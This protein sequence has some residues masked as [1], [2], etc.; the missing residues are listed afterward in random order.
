MTDT[1][2]DFGKMFEESASRGAAQLRTGDKVSGTITL[3][4]KETVFVDLGQRSDGY[5]DIKDIL[6]AK[7]NLK[8]KEGDKVEAFCVGFTDEGIK[9]EMRISGDIFDSTIQDAFEAKIP[10]EGKVTGERKGGYTVQIATSEAF[11]P[12]SQIDARGV[13]KE[14]AEYIGQ[15]YSFVVTEYSEDGHNLVISRRRILEEEAQR[16]HDYLKDLLKV[17]EIREGT[18]IKV[19]PFGAFVD[20]GGIEGLIP[21]SEISWSRDIKAEEALKEGDRVKVK[22]INIAWSDDN[23]N[24]DRLTLSLKQATKS[25][26]EHIATG[27]D[28]E[29]AIGTK[30]H[31]KVVRITD[32]G[33]FVQLVPGLDGLAHISQLGQESRVEHVSDVCKVGDEVDVTILGIDPERKRI[34]LCFGEPKV[35]DEVPAELSHEQEI[36]VVSATMGERLTGTVESLKPYGVFIKLPNGQT[37]MLHI[38]Q[39]QIE[40]TGP[41]RTREFYRKFPINSPVEVIVKSVEG[42][43]ISLTLPEIVEQ[44]LQKNIINDYKDEASAGFGNLG[45]LFGKLNL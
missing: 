24:K 28:P 39:A 5:L 30:H 43:R 16:M 21:V 14:P 37:G 40:E 27:D 25:P 8:Y 13:K 31:G 10:I 9:L 36:E 38:S 41:M 44:E 33:A 3:I 32:F 4:G 29:Y 15:A 7:G 11:C 23:S 1:S 26:W 45:D 18:V 22:I 20:L 19:L 17:D 34:S 2:N 42:N 6:D 35:K 12:F